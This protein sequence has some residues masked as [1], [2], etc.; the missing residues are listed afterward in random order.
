[1]FWLKQVLISID[2]FFNA[3]F[4][5]YADETMSSHLHRLR[6][7]GKFFGFIAY[8]VDWIAYCLGDKNHCEESYKS[9]KNRL[10]SPPEER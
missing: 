9:E 10:Q 5:G 2:Q 4:G 7:D 8:P 6:R 1:M 3:L